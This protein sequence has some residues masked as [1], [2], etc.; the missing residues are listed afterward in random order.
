MKSLL[1]ISML[2]A[3]AAAPPAQAQNCGSGG[4][5]TVCL[6][7]NGS[8]DNVRL[9]WAT[10]G[11]ASGFE[12]YRDTDPDPTGRV[13]IAKLDKAATSFVDASAVPG[14]RYWYWVRF[15][16]GGGAYNSGSSSA[17]RGA[18]CTPPTIVPYVA[19]G[20]SASQTAAAIAPVGSSVKFSPQ[21]SGSGAWSWNGCGTGGSAREQLFTANANCTATVTY[22]NTCDGKAMQPFSLTLAGA[23]RNLGSVE[24]G[25]QLVPGINLGNTLEAIPAE[26]SWGAPLT[27]QATMNAFKA[28]GF[29]SVRIP[30]SWSQYADADN[31]ISPVWMARVK[32]VVDY[33]RN[34]GLY[35]IVNIHWDG[36]WKEHLTY[37]EQPA[38]NAKLTKFWTQIANTF[39]DYD[40]HLLFAGTNEEGMAAPWGTPV[41]PEWIAV[42]NG[43]NQTFV[44]AVRATGGNNAVRHLVVQAYF[45]NIDYAV[46]INTV[47]TDTVA[48]R[49]FMEV[50]YYDPYD[51]TINGDS[52]IWQWGSIATDAS[53]TET[54]A[55]EP[56]VDAQFQK[57]ASRFVDKGVAVLIGEYG[58][59]AK[60]KYPGMSTYVRY[61][62]ETI[63]RSIVK[64]GGVPV[65]WDTGGLF[66]RANGAPKDPDLIAAIVNAAK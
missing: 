52:T 36:G 47:P 4:G 9:D 32:Q 23:M 17:A 44:N 14:T 38:I 60:P 30:V 34:A 63:T 42:Q 15:S 62:N 12:V 13:R 41:A 51:F 57:L 11:A 35:A 6:I 18:M 1:A 21:A 8:P 28:A 58:A 66:D 3:L 5:T 65:Y 56:W 54:W 39:K 20:G 25:R 64:H 46:T 16:N 50:H 48:S 55:N 2:I 24:L 10:S 29:K 33:A 45:T 40:D 22:T 37:A 27:T 53:A 43:L 59:Y 19:V 31:N 7:A 49:L 26:T 61:W